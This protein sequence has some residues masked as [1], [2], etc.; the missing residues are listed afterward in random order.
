M[1]RLNGWIWNEALLDAL[2][3]GLLIPGTKCKVSAREDK[4]IRKA[5][6]NVWVDLGC[7]M[8][9]PLMLCGAEVGEMN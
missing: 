1:E 7:G 8:R 4:S 6:W 3:G 5:K 2:V 9:K